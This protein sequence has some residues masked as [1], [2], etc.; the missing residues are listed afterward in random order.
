[1][2]SVSGQ[3]CVLH[4]EASP[5][6]FWY[7]LLVKDCG[8]NL[9]IAS[10][11]TSRLKSLLIIRRSLCQ[12][13]AKEE[14]QRK[15][16]TTKVSRYQSLR[17]RKWSLYVFFKLQSLCGRRHHNPSFKPRYKMLM[18]QFWKLTELETDCL[19]S[20]AASCVGALV[21]LDSKKRAGPV[22]FDADTHCCTEIDET[23]SH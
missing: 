16:V 22:G 12:I 6:V 10:C 20:W 13:H 18:V 11:V 4:L 15:E 1:M 21:H 17:R 2:Q 19:R 7:H 14:R 5:S 8:L 3:Q 23:K 9:L